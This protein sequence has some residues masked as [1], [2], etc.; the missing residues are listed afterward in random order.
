MGN[1]KYGTLGVGRHTS[2]VNGVQTKTYTVWSDLVAR[3]CS[4]EWKT[5]RPEHLH[6]D[7]CTDWLDFQVFAEWYETQPCFGLFNA[8]IDKDLLGKS[9]R[10]YAPS[11][12]CLLPRVINNVLKTCSKQRGTLPIGVTY[13]GQ[14]KPYRACL[15]IHGKTVC[16]GSY[17]TT[18]E[19]FAAYKQGKEDY[20][21]TLALQFREFLPNNA[22]DALMN[23]SV[24]VLD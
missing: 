21:K 18:E 22:F 24:S 7:M 1:R 12:T 10:M 8:Q 3:C 2:S 15:S 16:F 13:K 5:R 23:F 9:S 20:V 4:D 11:T 14:I 6:T 19:A 17:S